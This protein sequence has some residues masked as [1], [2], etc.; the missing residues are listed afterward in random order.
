VNVSLHWDVFVITQPHVVTTATGA[1]MVMVTDTRWIRLTLDMAD[2]SFVDAAGIGQLKELR[3]R[4][5]LL[6]RSSLVAEQLKA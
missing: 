4:F 5:T 3:I 1:Q 6:N 2:V